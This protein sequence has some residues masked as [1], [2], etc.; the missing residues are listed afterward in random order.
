VREID[1]Q[2]LLQNMPFGYACFQIVTDAGGAPVD[3]EFI[4][5]N[6][7]FEEL[8]GL[9]RDAVLGKTATAVLPE[10]RK[11][12][13]D[14]I[15]FYGRVALQ[16]DREQFE[17]YS[18]VLDR[19]FRVDA[20]APEKGRFITLLRDISLEKNL[21]ESS[22]EFLRSS[23]DNLDYQE[24]ADKMRTIC[25]AAY[26]TFQH[27]TP[28]GQ[29]VAAPVVSGLADAADRVATRKIGDFI[30]AMPDGGTM[31]NELLAELYAQQVSLLLERHQ[32]R[33]DLKAKQALIEGQ[34]E[35][36]HILLD[37]IGIQIWYLTDA[38]TYGM[39]N[40][41]HAQFNGMKPED[42]AGKDIYDLYPKAQVD[43]CVASNKIVFDLGK[44]VRTEEH[45]LCGRHTDRIMSVLK[46][47]KL[48]ADGRV[49]YV[50]CTAEDITENRI[51]A[52][53]LAESEK[54]FHSFFETIDDLIFI[55]DQQG[56]IFFTNQAVSRKL[57]YTPEELRGMH[58]LDVHARNQRA[59][60]EGIFA[61]MFAG[62][63][64]VCPLPLAHKNGGLLPVET[65]V[66]FGTWDGRDCIFGISKDLSAEQEALQKFDKLFDANPAL[67]AVSRL[68]ERTFTE[69]NQ[70]FLSLL[71]YERDQIIGK[72]AQELGIFI[73]DEEQL[74][75]SFRL[76]E[77]GRLAH[78]EVRVRARDGTILTGLF[79]GEVIESQGIS[80]FLTVMTDI[81]ALKAAEKRLAETNRLLEDQAVR[82]NSLA[83]QADAANRSKSEF[84]ANMSH[85]IRT[86]LNGVIGFAELLADT[87]LNEVQ[88]QYLDNATTSAQ[89]LL[90]IVNDILDLSKIEAGKLEL[91][92]V[93]TDL[94]ELLEQ[95][96]D[97]IKYPAAK[98]K[99][100]LLLDVV[101]AMP[102]FVRVDPVRL[103][104]ILINLLHNAVK[105][106]AA[107]EIE[108][109]VGF[110]A[111]NAQTGSFTFTVRDT[112]IGISEEQERNLFKAFSQADTSTT[113]K[114]G[115]TGLGLIISNLLAKK[116][117]T[118]IKMRSVPGQGTSFY[119]TLK[120]DY[121]FGAPVPDF[122]ASK[123]RRALVIDDHAGE[124]RI[125]AGLLAR[126]GI[127]CLT[128]GSGPEARTLVR[129][130]AP[131]DAVIADYS[132]PL[133][134]GLETIRLI[135]Q[136]QSAQSAKIRYLLLCGAA[137]DKRVLEQ[138]AEQG[139]HRTLVK[140]VKARE[141]YACLASIP[142]KEVRMIEKDNS[143]VPAPERNFGILI[144]EDNR[145]NTMLITA[146]L[147]K[148]VPAAV[149][150]VAVNGVE[151]VAMFK[152]GA[153]DLILMDVQ[154]PEMD[155]LEATRRIRE[156]EGRRGR[157][158]PIVALTAGA[159]KEERERCLAAGMD[160]FLTKPI[161]RDRLTE[162]L[163]RYLTSLPPEQ[164]PSIKEE[165]AVVR[166]HFDQQAV[167]EGIEGDTDL[168]GQLITLA[169][170][171]VP[172][173]LAA[174]RG[175][176]ESGNLESIRRKAHALKGSSHTLGL[177]ALAAICVR[178]EAA[179]NTAADY[180]SL[181]DAAEAEWEVVSALLDRADLQ[182]GTFT[183]TREEP[184]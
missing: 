6:E 31:Q 70:A 34:A 167:L 106:T 107:G 68:P 45:V 4:D 35:Q 65:R 118:S 123:V 164:P 127:E 24:L 51:A 54:N 55:A 81:S 59:E 7:R 180:S 44:P 46:N 23:A 157:S 179:E 67:M 41:A 95:A 131:F 69:V 176:L 184:R 121:A 109:R 15:A 117:G 87:E 77:T 161:E 128:C 110:C 178:L 162:V 139:V 172:E 120:A 56:T 102:R 57:G 75:I 183:E 12:S 64:D 104:Q 134:D 76:R 94:E 116:M 73:D 80:Y 113:R 175:G 28:D 47:P 135:R 103:R 48:G 97:I 21:I 88:K 61:D 142:E 133:P 25:G 100:T 138:A 132:L 17:Q 82:A 53:T 91:D 92:P 9:R 74:A 158:T 111:A 146:L 14:W 136:D 29:E 99:L 27:R 52:Q 37:N 63:R 40:R 86:P 8:S 32:S 33:V 84:L 72:T 169:R 155:G 171:S 90:G 168:L 11:S 148:M 159:V 154:M 13:F 129:E 152:T 39:V 58:V 2:A 18:P 125:I 126:Q 145:M 114:F 156:A 143:L 140:P 165:A 19:W 174:M 160:E 71:G 30:V 170:T 62:K 26:V 173:H 105:F 78:Q 153:P 93:D 119:F 60:A 42:M 151:A 66:W 50:V 98:K 149:I 38:H 10:I 20:Y 166:G 182:A 130:S 79:A 137:E 22:H 101:E 122:T 5:M 89:S 36:Q 96:M 108:L 141:L 85:E 112:G 16:G 147:R 144:A 181:L 150:T 163:S 3:Y 177:H 83:A 49:E 43:P 124:G 1:Y 115:G